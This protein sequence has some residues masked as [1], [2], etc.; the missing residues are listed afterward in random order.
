MQEFPRRINDRAV[1]QHGPYAE[2]EE[3]LD[4]DEAA[5]D[6]KDL[7]S[8]QC[9]HNLRGAGNRKHGQNSSC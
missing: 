2:L 1:G 9:G 5:Q 4:F 7:Q 3:D 6:E 8:K